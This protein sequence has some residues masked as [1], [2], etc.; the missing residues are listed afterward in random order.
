ME[1]PNKV[2]LRPEPNFTA[3][4]KKTLENRR[5]SQMRYAP[6]KPLGHLA[7][8]AATTTAH[9]TE[10]RQHAWQPELHVPDMFHDHGRPHCKLPRG[11]YSSEIFIVFLVGYVFYLFKMLGWREEGRKAGRKEGSCKTLPRY[12]ATQCR[13]HCSYQRKIHWGSSVT[14]V[15]WSRQVTLPQTNQLC[16]GYE[17]VSRLLLLLLVCSL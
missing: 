5:Q 6:T 13:D 3:S 10:A 11:V 15:F 1:W 7:M 2:R 8:L 16:Q 17:P 4:K 12:P 9:S 14:S